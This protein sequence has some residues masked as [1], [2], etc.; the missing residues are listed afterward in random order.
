MKY[1]L[2]KAAKLGGFDE[3]Y[4]QRFWG[5]VEEAQMPVSFNL[6]DK[7]VGEIW[8]GMPIEFEERKMKTSAKGNDYM[9]LTKVKL[10]G[11]PIKQTEAPLPSDQGKFQEIVLE[12]LSDIESALKDI[13]GVRDTLDTVVDVDPEEEVNLNSI[14]F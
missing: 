2:K 11:A 5:E 10:M 4:G 9:H 14:P 1:T 6:M 12:K 7:T 3:T 13:A 8:A